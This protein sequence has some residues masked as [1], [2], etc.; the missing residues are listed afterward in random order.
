M[1]IFVTILYV[2]GILFVILLIIT[3]LWVINLVV[4]AMQIY[5]KKNKN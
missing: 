2:L 3:F 4:K 5:I 1:S